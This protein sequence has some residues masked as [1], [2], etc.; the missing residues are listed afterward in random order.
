MIASGIYG[1]E[2]ARMAGTSTEIRDKHCGHFR[3]DTMR[4]ATALTN[5]I[6]HSVL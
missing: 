3:L 4:A 1:F 2:A 6:K 5:T